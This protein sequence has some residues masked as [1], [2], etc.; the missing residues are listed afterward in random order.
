VFRSKPKRPAHPAGRFG[1]CDPIE[2][3]KAGVPVG[4][5]GGDLN[6]T[7]GTSGGEATWQKKRRKSMPNSF[8]DGQNGP[9]IHPD[10]AQG[11]DPML[12]A[13]GVRVGHAVDSGKGKEETPMLSELL[14]E[15][16][17]GERAPGDDPCYE[18]L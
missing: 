15:K 4:S 7:C 13:E 1:S 18:G 14:R 11:H 3:L 10:Q 6:S 2:F 9:I 12:S 5:Q 8:T 16:S 17:G